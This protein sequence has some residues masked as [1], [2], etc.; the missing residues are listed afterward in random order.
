M[1]TTVSY[2]PFNYDL[3][4]KNDYELCDSCNPPNLVKNVRI[5]ENKAYP[6]YII[7]GEIHGS[8]RTWNKKG[9]WLMAG[10]SWVDLKMI[11]PDEPVEPADYSEYA[12]D[13][14]DFI[15]DNFNT[16]KDSE[17]TTIKE[18]YKMFKEARK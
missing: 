10:T 18:A 8:S 5:E 13:F 15:T 6:E 14:A 11:V 4:A 16:K 2:V 12:I 9:H 1:T 7:K 3:W 17:G